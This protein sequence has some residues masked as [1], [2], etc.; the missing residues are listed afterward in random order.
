[1][2][3][4]RHGD[5]FLR[6]VMNDS[7]AAQVRA[8]VASV[9]TWYHRIEVRP[10]IVTPGTND[11]PE[12]LERLRLPSDCT[13]LSALDI[14]TRD[15]FFAF[16]LERRGARVL[17]IDY[18]SPTETGFSVAADLLNSH[19]QYMQENVYRLSPEKHGLFDIVLFLGVLYHLP[20]LLGALAVLRGVCGRRLYLETHLLDQEGF[21]MPDG[22]FQSIESI[23]P[24]LRETPILQ[25]YPDDTLGGDYTNFWAP[26]ARC[27]EE[28]LRASGFAVESRD[29]YADRGVFRCLTAPPSAK[30]GFYRQALGA[31]GG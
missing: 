31:I 22:T 7:N 12:A 30:S 19:V 28:M 6:T 1:M 25:F 2:R 26:N 20:D 29:V 23:S 13:G 16:E 15:G 14:G 5:V 3:E 27:M 11:S 10:G 24:V 17:A 9:K 21:L 8:R 4:A 18:L